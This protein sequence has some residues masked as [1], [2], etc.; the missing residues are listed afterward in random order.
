MIKV[1]SKSSYGFPYVHNK[2]P[3]LLLLLS[4]QNV[5]NCKPLYPHQSGHNLG[6]EIK[7][8]SDPEYGRSGK[9][10]A[11]LAYF[12]TEQKWSRLRGHTALLF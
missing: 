3:Q 8:I 12:L 9:P 7:N 10:C 5:Y 2:D 1:I 4:A 11:C 6:F